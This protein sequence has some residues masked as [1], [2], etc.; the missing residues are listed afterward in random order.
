MQVIST[1]G[2]SKKEKKKREVA[3]SIKKRN[4]VDE[5]KKVMFAMK[6]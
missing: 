3:S 6:S 1:E 2:K 5:R 4:R